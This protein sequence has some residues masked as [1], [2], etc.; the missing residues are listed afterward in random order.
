MKK[1]LLISS[2]VFLLSNIVTAQQDAQYTQFMFNRLSYN[3]AYAGT[4]GKK[5]C[6]TL[7]F[8]SQWLGF[9]SGSGI[10]PPVGNSD[11][12]SAPVTFLGNIHAPIGNHFGLGLSISND[13]IGF[14][15]NINP[16]L[17]AS[18]RHTFTN[19]SVLSAGVGV[20]FMQ[21][22]L[23]GGKLKALDANDPL[24][25][26]SDVSARSLDLNFGLYYTMPSLWKF[27]DFYAGISATHLNQGK[28]SYAL[29]AGTIESQMR[30]HYYFTTGA[31]YNGLMGGNLALEPNI[32]VKFD[33]AKL[34]TDVNVM[35]MYNNKYR[36]GLTYRSIDA[37]SLLVGY[38]I[39]PEWQIGAS[40]D[41]TTSKIRDFSSGTIEVMLKYCFILK[42]DTKPDKLPIPRLT[43]RF[44]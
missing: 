25:P 4:E 29:P 32:L 18:Y 31:V 13:K 42:T 20:G 44:L 40:Y 38:K 5:I 3:P 16:V 19:Y 14:Q 9:G 35:A 17:S 12:G 41:F 22:S 10:A 26:T 23:A 7:M 2:F 43:P 11:I 30:M 37:L 15:N 39:K 34:T 28:L 33:Q 6:G 21:Q 24:V 36:A 8:R 27:N 1:I